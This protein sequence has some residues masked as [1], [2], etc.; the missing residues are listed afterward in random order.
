MTPATGALAGDGDRATRFDGASGGVI[1][2]AAP[3]LDTA[4][5][6]AFECWVRLEEAAADRPILEYAG[7]LRARTADPGDAV[8]VDFVDVQGG[9]HPV[10]SAA[11]ALAVDGWTHLAGTY[12]GARGRL[13]V[14]GALAGEVEG[15]FTLATGGDL[16]LAS[17]PD[18]PER[19]R[20]ALDEVAIFDRAL[21]SARVRDHFDLG[22]ADRSPRTGCC[23]AGFGER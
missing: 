1:V 6:L 18:A 23:S 7:G 4:S 3:V 11:G 16:H 14:N 15:A 13:Y 5:E 9:S 21:P 19:L 17:R 8:E 20:G 2:A 10:A 22:A 12:D